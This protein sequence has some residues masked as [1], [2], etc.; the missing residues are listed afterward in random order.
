MEFVASLLSQGWF[1]AVV[2]LLGLAAAIAFYFRSKRKTHLAYQHAHV[3]LIG[4][5]SG[6]AF[7]E[8]V[9][10]RFAGASVPRITSTRIVLWNSG[11]RTINGS[12]LVIGDHLRLELANDGLILKHEIL[13][14]TRDVNGW[15]VERSAPNRLNVSFDFLDPRDGISLEVIHTELGRHLDLKGTIKGMPAGFRDYGRVG[16]VGFGHSSKVRRRRVFQKITLGAGLGLCFF[17][18]SIAWFRSHFSGMFFETARTYEPRSLGFGM[19]GAGVFYV[20]LF[21]LILLMGRKRYPL[22]LDPVLKDDVSE[23]P[24]ET[25][26]DLGSN[27]ELQRIETNAPLVPSTTPPPNDSSTD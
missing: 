25:G 20:L 2:G 22:G 14:Q 3:T 23:S 7:P 24:A 16:N 26:K 6:A 9:E 21:A 18:L 19:V 4:G 8:E 12:D 17:G 13:Q 10:V 1:G 15:S 11:D 5:G 27:I